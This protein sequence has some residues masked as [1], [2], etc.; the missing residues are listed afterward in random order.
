MRV[1]KAILF[2]TFYYNGCFAQAR[3]YTKAGNISFFSKTTVENIQ[4]RNNKVLCVWEI[5]SGKIEFSV[6]MKGFEFE[7]ALMQEH[8]NENYVESDKYPKANFKGIVENSS[9]ISFSDTKTHTV[10]VNGALTLH[11]ITKQINIAATIKV[12]NGIAS[13]SSNFSLLL[14]DYNIRIPSLVADNINKKIDI[15]INIPAFIAQ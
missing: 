4:A 13:A 14:S 8:F 5:A 3:L 12:S 11:G 6:L 10:K 9:T 15:N 7:K 1:F 2:F